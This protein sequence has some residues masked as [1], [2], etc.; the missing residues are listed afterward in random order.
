MPWQP[1]ERRVSIWHRAANESTTR[2]VQDPI[3][4]Y[5]GLILTKAEGNMRPGIFGSSYFNEESVE[6]SVTKTNVF[7]RSINN[8]QVKFVDSESACVKQVL[9]ASQSHPG[10]FIGDMSPPVNPRFKI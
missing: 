4:L 8:L 5:A 1:E 9:W 7:R 10:R 3:I 6:V 2:E